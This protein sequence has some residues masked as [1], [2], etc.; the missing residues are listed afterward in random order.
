MRK[1]YLGYVDVIY[2]RKHIRNVRDKKDI[3]NVESVN[4]DLRHY[5]PLLE[6]RSRCFARKLDTLYSVVV[7]FVDAYNHFDVEKYKFRQRN[8]KS[9]LHFS[10][11]DF[12]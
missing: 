1:R 9:E 3:H 12:L 6:R 4:A 5:M 8:R 2:P 11:I 7:V 10:F